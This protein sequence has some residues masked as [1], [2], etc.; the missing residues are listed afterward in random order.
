MR[1]GSVLGLALASLAAPAV[2]CKGD[3]AGSAA[4]HL[5]AV[6]QP[7][8]P[9]PD[10]I[11]EMLDYAG[12]LGVNIADMKKLPEGVLYDDVAVGGD[13]L[14][15]AAG[16]SVEIRYRGWLP[17]GVKVDSGEV[18]MRLG[19]GGVVQG[20]ELAIPGMRA[21]GKRRLV[22]APGLAYGPEGTETVPPNSVLVY[23]LEL[24]RIIR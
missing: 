22:L 17:N 24:R 7:P 9:P 13:S 15:A 23:D 3:S 18:A 4:Q 19:G 8:A 21:G 16:D 2:S 5:R 20:V 1:P 11:P 14:A 6:L 12:S 10:T